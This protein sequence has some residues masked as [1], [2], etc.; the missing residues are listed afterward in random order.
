MENEAG[1]LK[2]CAKCGACNSVC[3][4]YAVKLNESWSPRGRL[5]LLSS[6]LAGASA[7]SETAAPGLAERLKGCALCG[8]C[9]SRCP[10]GLRPT[11]FIYSGRA[12]IV[13]AGRKGRL[14][15]KLAAR[16]ALSN[17]ARAIMAAKAGMRFNFI[18]SAMP[19]PI[20]FPGHPLRN[21]LQ[22]VKPARAIGRVAVF[23]GCAANYL[24]PDIGESLINLLAALGYEVVLPRAEA[25][26]GAPLRALGLEDEAKELAER[27]IG[28]FGKLN[29]EAVISPC[30]TCTYALKEQYK[31]LLGKGIPE[32]VEAVEFLSGVL[33]LDKL[34]SASGKGEDTLW[35][36]PCH[37]QYGLKANPA[38][39]LES[40]GIEAAPD[41][42]CGFSLSITSKE[43]AG[44]FL[45]RRV[46]ALKKH[47]QIITSCP[48]CILQLKK[49]GLNATHIVKLIEKRLLPS[50]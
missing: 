49:G 4:V 5:A 18:R 20:E 45:A 35:H 34:R 14:L 27:N 21:E 11:E 50:G 37:L 43:L 44:E 7:D 1:R 12:A 48:A 24:M 13:R 8:R 41:G 42:C 28:I 38:T 36:T 40:L 10:A 30:P 2:D 32:A 31:N 19:F 9:D 39:M 47:N 15:L 6:I 33:D 16:I 29:A 3:P 23:A 25:C 17:P 26:C 22:V 46:D